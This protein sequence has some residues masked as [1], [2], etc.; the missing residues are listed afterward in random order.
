M[1]CDPIVRRFE[2]CV[3][4]VMSCFPFTSK[5]CHVVIEAL[6][7]A[8]EVLGVHMRSQAWQSWLLSTTIILYGVVTAGK[9]SSPAFCS[10]RRRG[11]R[12]VCGHNRVLWSHSSGSP[13][14]PSSLQ[15]RCWRIL[16]IQAVVSWHWVMTSGLQLF[17]L[18]LKLLGW[19]MKH[20]KKDDQVQM[21]QLNFKTFAVRNVHSADPTSYLMW[22]RKD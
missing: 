16:L 19:A 3:L 12:S 17:F 2:T 1:N 15:T 18:S 20:F 9:F 10:P 21:P 14:I 8:K 22:P 5:N 4:E 6:R 7:G 13:I 11:Q